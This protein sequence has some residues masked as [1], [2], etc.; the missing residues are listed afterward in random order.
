M[1]HPRARSKEL[2]LQPT[3]DDLVVFDQ[4]RNIAH[5]LN[6]TAALVFEHADGTRSV[7]DLVTLLQT[8]L[9]ETADEDLVEMTLDTLRRA[10][11]LEEA[12]PRSAEALRA[13]R[14]RFVRKIGLV[15]ALTLLLPAVESTVAPTPVMAQSGDTLCGPGF[16]AGFTDGGF[17]V[18]PDG[19]A[20]RS[21]L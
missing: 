15:G 4:E 8:E 18:A 16:S 2:L 19:P 11:L 12:G 13:S 17:T 10:H 14:R 9:N 6:R 1:S 3:G 7:A 20:C 5:T 21:G